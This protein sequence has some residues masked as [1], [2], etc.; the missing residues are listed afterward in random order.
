MLDS[1]GGHVA[2]GW[3]LV[4][5]VLTVV[6]L[7]ALPVLSEVL[8]GASGRGSDDLILA[9]LLPAFA[10]L[11]VFVAVML[12]VGPRV[13]PALLAWTESHGGRELFILAVCTI[14][15]GI[16]F[17]AAELLDVPIAIAAFLA[18]VVVNQ[19]DLSHRA[20]ERTR[21]LQDIFAVL[22]FV[23]VGM[24]VDPMSFLRDPARIGAVV[25]LVVLGKG[26]LALALV[27]LLRRPLSTGFTVAAGL[28]QVGEFS[29]ILAELGRSLGLL[30]R[31]AES[32]ILAGALVSITVNPLLF[33]LAAWA[34]ERVGQPAY[35]GGRSR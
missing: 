3:L 2:V 8:G 16:A 12:I 20:M 25:A 21:P 18:G 33:H 35:V 22:F 5:D 10:K 31:E 7:V 15:L 32:L 34:S 26:M 19:A 1:A 27:L 13:I 24:L 17:L 30:S 14:A 23:S 9:S 4:E 29:F 28:S 6:M 11:A